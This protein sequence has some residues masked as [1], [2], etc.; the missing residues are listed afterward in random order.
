MPRPFDSLEAM[1][2]P[3]ALRDL[4][5][6]E[7]AEVK[8]EPFEPAGFSS[9]ET[10]FFGV[11]LDGELDSDR[12]RDAS[13]VGMAGKDGATLRRSREDERGGTRGACDQWSKQAG[14]SWVA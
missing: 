11:R 14:P 1:L 4:L 12:A 13:S 7:V 8:L 3:G 9:T 2:D 5:G 6:R 10:M